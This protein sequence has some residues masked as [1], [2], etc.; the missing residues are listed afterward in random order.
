MQLPKSIAEI[1]FSSWVLGFISSEFE[2]IA[3]KSE[4]LISFEEFTNVVIFVFIIDLN[5]SNDVFWL[6]EFI[7]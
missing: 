3:I 5:T 4:P 2:I 6:K 7:I 1:P